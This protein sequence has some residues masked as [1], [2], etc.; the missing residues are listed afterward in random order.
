MSI[1]TIDGIVL[2]YHI[3]SAWA[4]LERIRHASHTAIGT[5]KPDIPIG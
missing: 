1:S 3:I 5:E 4:I 2:H